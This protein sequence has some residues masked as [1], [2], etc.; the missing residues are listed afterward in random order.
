MKLNAPLLTD[1]RILPPDTPRQLVVLL[2]GVG[3][4][5]HDLIDLGGMWQG[6]LPHA[7]F[8]SPNGAQPYDM[9]PPELGQ[10]ARQWFSLRD[11]SQEV[12]LAEIQKTQPIIDG[13]LDGLLREFEL[14]ASNMALVGFSQGTMLSLFIGPRRKEQLAGILCYSGALLGGELLHAELRSKP[15]TCLIHGLFDD[16]VPAAASRMA[17]SVFE[18]EAI[19]SELHMLENLGHGINDAGLNLGAAFLQ[20]LFA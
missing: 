9:A 18:K 11:R 2:H 10:S 16:V 19:P 3:A 13:Y 4:N 6:I 15:P 17:H 12:M 8:I 7:A 14:P 1:T 20:R 5:A